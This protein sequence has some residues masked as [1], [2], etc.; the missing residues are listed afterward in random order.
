MY[1]QAVLHV[2]AALPRQKTDS[3]VSPY[4]A[5]DRN[6]SASVSWIC[7]YICS[8]HSLVSGDVDRVLVLFLQEG[9][10]S[11]KHFQR[12]WIGFWEQ[13]LYVGQRLWPL[14]EP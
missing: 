12:K 4:T 11:P 2:G 6:L 9:Q 5:G 13:A 8:G 3:T 1:T 7:S 10:V 14:K